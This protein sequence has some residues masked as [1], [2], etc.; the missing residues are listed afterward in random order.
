MYMRGFE[1]P[2]VADQRVT[3]GFS[4][5]RAPS[6]RC[7]PRKSS[8]RYDSEQGARWDSQ[9]ARLTPFT[10]QRAV[11]P[12]RR[13]LSGPLEESEMYVDNKNCF[14]PL[15]PRHGPHLFPRKA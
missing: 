10:D 6:T 15:S 14:R 7:F 5:T 11:V 8:G 1:G 12:L 2:T 3:Y 13:G 4:L 9:I